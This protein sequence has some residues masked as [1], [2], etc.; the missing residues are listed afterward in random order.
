VKKL[1]VCSFLIVCG[2]SLQ[3]K[4]MQFN[5]NRSDFDSV[6][7]EV[8][9]ENDVSLIKTDSKEGNDLVSITI[10]KSGRKGCKVSLSR[11]QRSEFGHSSSQHSI[12]KKTLFKGFEHNC[13]TAIETLIE[14][15]I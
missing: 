14:S 2:L 8:A 9:A 11:I 10:E 5:T 4:E 3:A 6:I 13:T 15:V 1:I 7:I 12:T